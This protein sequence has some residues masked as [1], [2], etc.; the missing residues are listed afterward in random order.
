MFE[1]HFFNGTY[2]NIVREAYFYTWDEMCELFS[3]HTITPTKNTLGFICAKFKTIN[4]KP[5]EQKTFDDKGNV[6]E[7]SQKLIDGNTVVGRYA[8]NIISYNC[9]VFDY[10]GN[11]IDIDA[12]IEEFKD[13]QYIGYTSH[14]HIIS[15]V[16]KFRMI[17]PFSEPCPIQEWQPRENSFREFGG[18]DDRSTTAKARIFFTPTCP[19]EG[20]KYKR[21]WNN[22][23]E[24]LDWQVF[25]KKKEQTHQVVRSTPTSNTG[26]GKIRFDTFNMVQFFKDKGLYG[27]DAG[28]GKHDVKCFRA[29]EHL[30]DKPGGTVVWQKAGDW[31]SFYCGHSHALTSK[32]F[33][34][35]FDDRN[36]IAKYCER[37]LLIDNNILNKYRRK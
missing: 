33:W 3:Q 35:Y 25:D 12:K 2:D 21:A 22:K 19:E 8:E 9:L 29:H 27:A 20:T 1:L 11:G 16:H 6:V 34:E 23:G 15:G 7:V 14:N 5:A 18:T 37:E 13:F 26:G 17:F 32:D 10:D 36:E 30:T 28:S 31:P 4:Y 24:I